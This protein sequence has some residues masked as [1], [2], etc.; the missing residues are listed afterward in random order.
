MKIAL[1]VTAAGRSLRFGSDKLSFPFRGSSMGEMCL[2]LYSDIPFSDKVIVI[3]PLSGKWTQTIEKY[4]FRKVM[5]SSPENG[6]SS[7][8][9]LAI[10]LILESDNPDG[11]LFAAADMPFTRH[12]SVCKLLNLFKKNPTNICALSYEDKWGKPVIFPKRLFSVLLSLEG[13]TGGRV[14]IEKEL[15]DLKTVAVEKQELTDIDTLSEMN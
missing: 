5:N 1:I 14:L 2:S 8:L 7:S 10:S 6:L 11:I 4:G 15:F 3:N 13:D 9:A 12:D